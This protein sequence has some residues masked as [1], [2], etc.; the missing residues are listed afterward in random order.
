MKFGV[1]SYSFVKKLNSGEMTLFDAID[2]AKGAGY[3]AM[4]FADFA[5]VELAEPDFAK[6]VHYPLLLCGLR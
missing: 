2:F 3:D 4:D 5:P 6:R 1:S